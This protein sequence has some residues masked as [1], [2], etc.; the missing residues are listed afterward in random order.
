MS[1][2]ML[3]VGACDL[4]GAGM[5]GLMHRSRAIVPR[6]SSSSAELTATEEVRRP[7]LQGRLSL[8]LVRRSQ[9][10]VFDEG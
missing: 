8:G 1:V 9:A 3:P 6:S 10:D 7:R 4:V 5:K 2:A